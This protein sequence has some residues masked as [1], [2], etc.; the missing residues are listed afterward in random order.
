MAQSYIDSIPDKQWVEKRKHYIGGSEVAAILGIS[1][2]ATPLQVWMRK[3]GLIPAI[4]QTSI[5]EF[6]NVFE[7]VMA[8]YFTRKTGL[9]IRNIRQAFKSREHPYL[10]ANIDRQILSD[11]KQ[12]TGV[13]ELKTTT[14]YRLKNLETPYPED[15]DYQIQHYLGIT[16]YDYA[17]L[18]IYERD[19][20]RFHEPIRIQRNEFWIR[21]TTRRL[22]EWWQKYM[23]NNQ[24]PAPVNGED[25]LILYPESSDNSVTEATAENYEKYAKLLQVRSRKD[26]LSVMEEYLKSYFKDHLKDSERMV[27]SGQTL[28]SWK[29]TESNRF[30]TSRFKKQHPDLYK[31]FVKSVSTR[32]FTVTQQGGV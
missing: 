24:K 10:R 26:E 27:R 20:C 8:E 12:G 21:K 9:K 25:M 15:W 2:Y 22:V 3:K 11:G 16:G 31:K 7:P 6:G 28:V 29:S 18:F 1:S 14:S 4:D 23:V 30:D 17:Y 32:R 19:T 13:L 5:M